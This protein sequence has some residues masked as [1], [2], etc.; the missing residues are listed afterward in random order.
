MAKS[1]VGSS[2]AVLIFILINQVHVAMLKKK[3][4][5][6]GLIQ[7]LSYGSLNKKRRFVELII[8][9]SD[10]EFYEEEEK[11]PGFYTYDSE[12]EERSLESLGNYKEKKPI[13]S[14]VEDEEN[15]SGENEEGEHSEEEDDDEKS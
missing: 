4:K 13:E 11:E 15:E 8:H 2:F 1:L 14:G 6:E 10:D 9:P 12:E 5:L 7:E 3:G